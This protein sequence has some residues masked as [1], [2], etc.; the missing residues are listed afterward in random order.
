MASTPN[1]SGPVRPGG[2]ATERGEAAIPEP[3]VQSSVPETPN[4]PTPNDGLAPDGV[5]LSGPQTPEGAGSIPTDPFSQFIGR[6]TDRPT[7]SIRAGVNRRNPQKL[8]PPQELWDALPDLI[9][10]ARQPDAS[11]QLFMLLDLINQALD[12][13]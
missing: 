13:D 6:P 9:E 2:R 8:P 10:A 7:E 5:D 4:Q 12:Q 1:P 11:P 3:V